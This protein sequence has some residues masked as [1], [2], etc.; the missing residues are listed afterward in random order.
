VKPPAKLYEPTTEERAKF[1]F[2]WEHLRRNENYRRFYDDYARRREIPQTRSQTASIG[3]LYD[4]AALV[5]KFRRLAQVGPSATTMGRSATATAMLSEGIERAVAP[6]IMKRFGWLPVPVNPTDGVRRAIRQVLQAQPRYFQSVVWQRAQLKTMGAAAEWNEFAER[7]CAWNSRMCEEF[8]CLVADVD[9]NHELRRNQAKL[10]L[11]RLLGS[12]SRMDFAINTSLPVRTVTG[13]LEA[14]L[15]QI[16]QLRRL[17]S[18]PRNEKRSRIR[19]WRKHLKLYDVYRPLWEKRLAVREIGQKALGFV[20][21]LERLGLVLTGRDLNL[22]KK[23]DEHNQKPK[24][25]YHLLDEC[26]RRALIGGGWDEGLEHLARQRERRSGCRT[27]TGFDDDP[28]SSI[29][30]VVSKRAL[31]TLP[32]R[33]FG[34][35]GETLDKWRKLFSVRNVRMKPPFDK[36]L[37]INR[38]RWFH[39]ARERVESSWH[40]LSSLPIC[41]IVKKGN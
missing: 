24:D 27:K 23:L 18:L 28:S 22:A 7:G 33:Q 15:Q 38:N 1:A 3:E 17:V 10:E 19:D 39:W 8:N 13:Q 30:A 20:D 29:T 25:F 4:D 41:P 37:R 35:T 5:D 6:A 31:R 16:K 26:K 21:A 32:K 12:N 36:I 40:G 11:A 34:A 9:G 14:I 2:L